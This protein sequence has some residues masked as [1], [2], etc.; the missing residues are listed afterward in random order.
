MY[1]NLFFLLIPTRITPYTA[2]II[3]N[4]FTN[5]LE[6]YSFSGLILS[7]ISDHSPIFSM[8][9]EISQERDE[10]Y[11]EYRDKSAKNISNFHNR[12]SHFNWYDL[13]DIHDPQKATLVFL[14]NLMSY[15]IIV[16]LLKG[17]QRENVQLRSPGFPRVY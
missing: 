5:D 13:E 7:D 9:Y 4:I 10:A 17:L 14:I 2:T 8:S 15:L 1:T 6:N 3:D 12:L 16:F 11:I